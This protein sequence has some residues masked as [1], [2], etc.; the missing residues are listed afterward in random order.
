M[1]KEVRQITSHN[2][3]WATGRS[4]QFFIAFLAILSFSFVDYA[5]S[6]EDSKAVTAT[7]T[8]SWIQLIVA[9]FSALFFWLSKQTIVY[10]VKKNRLLNSLKQ[11]IMLKQQGSKTTKDRFCSWWKSNMEGKDTPADNFYYTPREY[12]IYENSPRDIIFLLNNENTN[13]IIDIYRNFREIDILLFNISGDIN[14]IYK[15]TTSMNEGT[16]EKFQKRFQRIVELLDSVQTAN[17]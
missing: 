3:F 12:T 9:G 16:K 4:A 11:E 15:A 17:I 7:P 1:S 14:D 13:S 8:I 2:T 10:I 5:L 6:S